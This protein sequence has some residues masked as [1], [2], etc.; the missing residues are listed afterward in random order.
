MLIQLVNKCRHRL[1]GTYVSCKIV[2][3]GFKANTHGGECVAWRIPTGVDKMCERDGYTV[4]TGISVKAAIVIYCT[5]QK[6]SQR[7]IQVY[8]DFYDYW[9]WI[10]DWPGQILLISN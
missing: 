7:S 2:K 4:R 8:N 1:V 10:L 5:V 3:L 9:T 6:S